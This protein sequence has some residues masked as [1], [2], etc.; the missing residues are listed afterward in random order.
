VDAYTAAM[1]K[2]AT[3]WADAM[4]REGL[5]GR[6]LL[7]LSSGELIMSSTLHEELQ[8]AMKQI[9]PPPVVAEWHQAKVEQFGLVSSFTRTMATSGLFA[10]LAY[11]EQGEANTTK[12]QAA[13]GRAAAACPAFAD[14]YREWDLQD[15][16]SD[17]I[18]STPVAA[19]T[20]TQGTPAP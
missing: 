16:K 1:L 11:T 12:R 10:G 20:P 5:L 7:T 13:Y 17:G 3:V 19:A 8:T 18:D 6:D 4:K 15:G 2:A 9:T 14:F